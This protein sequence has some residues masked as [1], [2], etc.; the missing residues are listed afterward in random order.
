MHNIFSVATALSP[1]SDAQYT[2]N[3][4]YEHV[5]SLVTF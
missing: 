4:D 2:G 5:M 3:F 1:S